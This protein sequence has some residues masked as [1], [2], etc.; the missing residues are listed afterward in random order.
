[1][2][3]KH[4]NSIFYSTILILFLFQDVSSQVSI[5]SDNSNP[6]ASSILDVKST[7]K[8]VLV[9]RM[10]TTQRTAISSPATGLLV[11]DLTTES[12]W[13]N[14]STGWMELNG[15][16]INSIVDADNDTKIQ[17]EESTNEDLIRF[18]VD[19]SEKLVLKENAF[20][21]ELPITDTSQPS[22]VFV[23]GRQVNDFHIVDYQALSML[24]ISASQAL[25]KHNENIKNEQ[26]NL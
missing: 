5:N 16:I 13:F 8:G 12:F 20:K 21:V 1:M 2:R 3:Q 19:G 6:D 17:V 11:F 4:I 23:Y 10:T 18:D 15:G 25:A 22:T 24:N 9:P 14:A 7:D 26:S